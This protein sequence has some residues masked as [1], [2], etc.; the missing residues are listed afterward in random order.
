[1][2]QKISIQLF[3]LFYLSTHLLIFNFLFS[4]PQGWAR[5]EALAREKVVEN[6]GTIEFGK[7][8]QYPTFTAEGI[9]NMPTQ[10][11]EE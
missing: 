2:P 6:G 7:W 1:M 11:E 4:V 5:R 8:Y 9:D 10:V 3:T